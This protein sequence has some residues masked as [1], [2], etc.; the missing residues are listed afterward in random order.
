DVLWPDSDG[1]AA[2]LSFI[3]TLHRLRQLLGY[4]KALQYRE[5]RLTLDERFCWLDIRAF[6]YLL[7]Q[8]EAEW[9]E[10]L[11][12]T[13]VQL[14]QKTIEVYKGDFLIGEPETT[15]AI[16]M[17]ERLKSKF[18]RTVNQ[19]ALYWK[20]SGHWETTL[21]CYQK[22]LEVDDNIEELYQNLMIC[23]QRLGQ[24][25]EAIAVYHRCRKTLSAALGI[26]PSSKTQA[27][28]RSLLSA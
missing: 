12:D 8:A 18:L 27:L 15:W 10:G 17:Q 5:G 1:D 4:E 14:S 23:H 20:S 19:T 25:T 9:K 22:A 13:S 16:S 3:T 11:S 21:A 6:E 26:E 24:K 7:G 28:Y 2:H